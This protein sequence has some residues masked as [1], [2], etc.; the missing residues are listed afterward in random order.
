M[1][2]GNWTTINGYVQGD[3]SYNLRKVLVTPVYAEFEITGFSEKWMEFDI[4]F[5]YRSDERYQW[6]EDSV[7][8]ETSA[9]YLR[10]NKIFGLQASKDGVVNT[11]FWKYSDNNLFY[12]SSPQI[13][14]RVLPRVRLFGNTN[15]KYTI[16]EAYGDSLLNMEGLSGYNIVGLDQ[17]GRY[18]GVGDSIFYIMDDLGSES[19]SSSDSSS[20]TFAM[21]SSSSSS[22]SSSSPGWI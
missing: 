2:I 4:A 14:L 5:E 10:G 21:T 17:S 12:G 11:I 1:S 8:T 19:L 15:S 3:I 6:M 18:M 20:S 22:S 9:N 13:R 16:V 7:I